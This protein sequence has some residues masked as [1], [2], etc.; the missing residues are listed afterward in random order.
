M[1]FTPDQMAA[2]D[3]VRAERVRLEK[4]AL[5]RRSML[6]LSAGL[7]AGTSLGL[8]VSG[9]GD[10][11][12]A[13]R[14]TQAAPGAEDDPTL[15]WALDLVDGES[16]IPIE[17]N[18]EVFRMVVETHSKSEPRLWIGVKLLAFALLDNAITIPEERRLV[19]CRSVADL[20]AVHG[21]SDS[22]EEDR[23]EAGLRRLI[24]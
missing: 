18:F 11:Q 23:L 9:A 4:R 21:N 20:F 1:G 13:L 24:K 2:A 17:R 7:L 12:A 16:A 15:R 19:L 22:S 3:E 6:G 5:T 14:P 8:F 10:S